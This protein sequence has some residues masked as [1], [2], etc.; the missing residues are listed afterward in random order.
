M[1]KEQIDKLIALIDAKIAENAA[2]G[3]SEGEVA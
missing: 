2:D 1:T 3:S